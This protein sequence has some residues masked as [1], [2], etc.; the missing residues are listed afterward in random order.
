MLELQANFM[1]GDRQI[2]LKQLRFPIFVL[3]LCI[4]PLFSQT[5]NAEIVGTVLDSS[6]AILPGTTVV[7]THSASG[8]TVERITDDQGGFLLPALPVG[9]YTI[10]VELPGFKRLV[11]QGIILRVGQRA[12]L[13]LVL[14]LGDISENI[15]VNATLPLLQK[16][17]AEIN[18]IIENERVVEL[19]LNSRHFLQLALLSEGVVKP[20]GGTRGAALQQAGDLVNVGGQR[21]G[22][23]I[24]MLDGV[25]VTDELFNNLVVSPSVDAIQE[26][27]IQKTMYSAE[28]GGKAS[29]LINVVMKSGTNEYHGNL[30]EF[31]RNAALDAKNFFDRPDE[32]IPPFVQNQF[33]GTFGGPL[34]I[35]QIYDG[36]NKTF[37][38][39]NYEG[40]RIR[41]SI[42][43]TFSVPTSALRSG[44]FSNL[45]TIYDP[46]TADPVTGE[47]Q[48]FPN[49]RIPTNRLDPVALAFLEKAPLPNL[50]GNVQNLVASPSQR[51]DLDQFNL[52]LDH[53]ASSSDTFF[54]RLSIFNADAFQPFGTTELSEDLLP[55]FGRGLS[56]RS[57]N[58]AVGYTHTF[59][60]EIVN[61]LR[62]GWL[63]VSGGQTS[64]NQGFDF[65]SVSGLQG[66]TDDPKD[67]GYPLISFAGEFNTMGDPDSFIF[68]ENESFELFENVSVRRGNH[69]IKFG[70][71]WFH[72][73]FNPSNPEAARGVFSFTPRFTSSQPGFSDGSSFAD[74][75]LGH[76]SS[77]KGGIGRGEEDGRTNWFHF[78]I[79]DDWQA[80]RDLTFNLGFRYEANQHMK[81]IENRLSAIDLSVPGG[82]FVI[83]SDKNGNI[84]PEADELMPL[85]PLPAVTSAEA[86]WSRSLLRPSFKR[87][88][89]RLGL[90][91][92][93]LGR[94]Q[95][96]VRAGFGIFPN[97]WAY[98]I[99]QNLARNL[100]FFFL[101][102]VD[103]ASDAPLPPFNTV[104]VLI[105]DVTGSVSGNNMDHEFRTEYTQTWTL[106]IQHLLTPATILDVQYMGSRTVGADNSTVRN[107]PLPG[108][109]PIDSRRPTPELS[110]FRSIRWNGWSTYHALT[111]KFERRFTQGLFFNT[112]YTWSKSID[113]ASAPG[114]TSFESNLPQDVGNLDAEK[115]LSSFHHA[116]AF[117]GS[118]TYEFPVRLTTSPGWSKA[119]FG[120]WKMTGIVTLQSGAPFTVNTTSDPANIGPGPAQRPNLVR[121]PNLS[122][123][124]RSPERW[125]DTEAFTLPAAY[126]FGNAGRNTVF[127]PG[128]KNFDFSLIKTTSVTERARL[129]F[130]AEFFNIFNI[131]NFDIPNRF[132]FTSNFGR[133]FSARSSRQIQ[134]A[135]KLSF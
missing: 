34:T 119:L 23:N 6:G 21:A 109:G 66:V 83:A 63:R 87:F 45:G 132:A 29:A 130:R 80:H 53:L 97:Q 75:L 1:R 79:Q 42:T 93:V 33:G 78:Y 134:F 54:A 4:T 88:A 127:S 72:L 133:I 123:S 51:T 38:F 50:P 103:T 24:Y 131:T 102:Q 17:S 64:E 104:D 129:E 120:G 82:R 47:R 98:S 22:H 125:F 67:M 126:T 84:S 85:I 86:G 99:Q 112:N 68:R 69:Q 117:T 12:S 114:G 89:P 18:D 73:R 135:L 76:P 108:P 28:F 124:Q 81:D 48:P 115:G 65:A 30:Y 74:F 118:F 32:P 3:L 31:H 7:A 56:T 107:V 37:F 15:T 26:F 61:E 122:S 8:F 71:Y 11:R 40:Q 94:S 2:D 58:V 57:R 91:W 46:L 77:A 41:Q 121:D 100:P 49:N 19:P 128:F 44:D 116:H 36:L 16:A 59:G 70:G 90:A 55:G 9:G 14:E 96:V 35:P 27:K 39:I 92:D 5:N 25:K 111:L 62:F 105:Q 106:S 113:D 43:K 10:T 13:D 95:T 20:P 110:G 60:S 101:K 52:R